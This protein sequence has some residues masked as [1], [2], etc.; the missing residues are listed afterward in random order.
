[1]ERTR[2]AFVLL[3]TIEVD[4]SASVSQDYVSVI[5]E[6]KTEPMSP[7]PKY[8]LFIAVFACA[9][10]AAGCGDDSVDPST[11]PEAGVSKDAT[12]EGGEAGNEGGVTITPSDAGEAGSESDGSTLSD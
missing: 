1:M 6:Q 3:I 5:R 2:E 9:L 11:P 7:M 4:V 10:P 8:L 12:S